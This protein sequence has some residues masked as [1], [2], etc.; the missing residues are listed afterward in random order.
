MSAATKPVVRPRDEWEIRE[1]MRT[2]VR[3]EEIR[4]DPKRLAA[5]RKMAKDEMQNL[6]KA[7][8]HTASVAAEKK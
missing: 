4:R 8:D 1:D 7:L 6:N 5:A 2:L 3:A